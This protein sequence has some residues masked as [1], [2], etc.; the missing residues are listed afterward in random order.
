M[1]K[2]IT[3]ADVED[4]FLRVLEQIEHEVIRGND[5]DYLPDGKFALRTDYR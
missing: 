5:E 3:E 2:I 1:K 4:D